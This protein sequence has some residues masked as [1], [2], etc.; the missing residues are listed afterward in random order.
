[1]AKL[2]G[3]LL[4]RKLILGINKY[5]LKDPTY[6]VV[7]TFSVH[8]GRGH[9]ARRGGPYCLHMVG[10]KM[11]GYSARLRVSDEEVAW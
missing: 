6:P 3:H 10:I 2:S 11:A 9:E 1:M 7:S 4:S 8:S 5:P